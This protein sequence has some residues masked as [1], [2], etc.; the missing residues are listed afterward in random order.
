MWVHLCANVWVYMCVNVH[1]CVW[2]NSRQHRSSGALPRDGYLLGEL[3]PHLRHSKLC[4][5][6]CTLISS[7]NRH[8]IP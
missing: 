1:M 4:F 3:S 6:H 7:F 8:K 2:P 5:M